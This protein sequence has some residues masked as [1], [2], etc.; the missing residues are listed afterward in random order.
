[1]E[2]KLLNRAGPQKHRAL[3]DARGV[4]LMLPKILAW[5]QANGHKFSH[6]WIKSALD[7]TPQ[8]PS[9]ARCEGRQTW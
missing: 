6:S 7:I 3:G 2:G 5:G 4:A 1:L 9:T 8:K